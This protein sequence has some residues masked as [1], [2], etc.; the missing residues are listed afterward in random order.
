MNQP[1]LNLPSHMK[2]RV[3]RFD[4]G[5][6]YYNDERTHQGKNYCGRTP[7]ETMLDVK[8]IYT[9]KNLAKI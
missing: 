2:K 9:E 8:S 6:E 1:G 3:I 4:K 7:K 5:V